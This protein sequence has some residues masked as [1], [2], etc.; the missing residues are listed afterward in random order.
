MRKIKK[1]KNIL[2]YLKEG[3]SMKKSVK[4]IMLHTIVYVMSI[5]QE[6]IRGKFE[7]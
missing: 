3:E 4:K 6:V 7:K 5:M 2:S 1:Y